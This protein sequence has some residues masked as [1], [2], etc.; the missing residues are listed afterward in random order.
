MK[1][2]VVAFLLLT[3]F[4]L[5]QA[6]GIRLEKGFGEQRRAEMMMKKKQSSTLMNERSSEDELENS[7]GGVLVCK[8]GEECDMKGYMSNVNT[9]EEREGD[10]DEDELRTEANSDDNQMEDVAEMDYSPARR[11]SPI[12][13]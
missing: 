13:N 7:N 9:I 6:Q 3:C 12:H 4:L 8:E 10:D 2:F 11:K 5:R 1:A